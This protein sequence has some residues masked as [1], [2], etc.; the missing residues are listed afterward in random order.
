MKQLEIAHHTIIREY[1]IKKISE[2][3]VFI[4]KET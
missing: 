4:Q 2:E 1:I 3:T